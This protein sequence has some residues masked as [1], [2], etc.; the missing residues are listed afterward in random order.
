MWDR[1]KINYS[2]HI[3]H[4]ETSAT[5]RLID[6][7]LIIFWTTMKVFSRAIRLRLHRQ[8]RGLQRF[9]AGFGI[10]TGFVDKK[11]NRQPYP[12]AA[13]VTRVCFYSLCVF[14]FTTQGMT[15]Q[16]LAVAS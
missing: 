7:F 2:A 14:A 1:L 10:F 8:H 12:S 9:T 3:H 16:M 13:C 11:K 6:V 15:A 5:F 4:N